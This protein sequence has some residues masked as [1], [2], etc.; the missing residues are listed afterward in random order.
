MPSS[1]I[2]LIVD[3]NP[4]GR[5]NLELLLSRQGYTLTFANSG[6]EALA[7]AVKQPPD[8]ILLDVMM[9]EM[10]GFEVCRRLR[11]D[12]LLREIPV[13]LLT[14]LGDRDS[15]LVGIEAG[16]D[17]F[18]SKP[19]DRTELRTRIKTILRLNRYRRLHAERL[20]FEWAVEHAN[21]GYIV[22]DAKGQIQYANPRAVLYLWGS[23]DKSKAPNPLLDQDFLTLAAQRY[24]FEPEASWQQWQ[25]QQSIPD[26]RLYLVRPETAQ[27]K[28][29]WLQVDPLQTSMGEQMLRLQDV[30]E[31]ISN[32]RVMWS[33][34][35]QVN[36]KLRTPLALHMGNLMLLRE[37]GAESIAHLDGDV[38]DTME[39]I[40]RSAE[41]LQREVQSVLSVVDSLSLAQTETD[42]FLLAQ[43]P[44]LIKFLSTHV[45]PVEIQVDARGAGDAQ[46]S[47]SQIAMEL[48][49]RELFE[50]A[51]KFH[52]HKCPQLK[53]TVECHSQHAIIQVQDDGIGL[54]PEQLERMWTPYYQ[55]EKTFTGQ[56]P[57]MGLGLTMASSLIWEAGGECRSFNRTDQHGLVVELRLPLRLD[58]AQ[59]V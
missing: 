36:H 50:N 56:V 25:T 49:L 52:P 3:D 8:L 42:G 58:D 5:E 18:I 55:V 53:V 14:A 48:V 20:R 39:E 23:H 34:Q 31:Q 46:L 6:A 17:D 30:T 10:D 33:F 7:Q 32:L 2:V 1:N 38:V 51:V 41:R 37:I 15:M 22:L 19:F 13:I 40:Y 16:A 28:T 47:I 59:I 44:D 57:G 45:L 21:E 11:A 24:Q 9:P 29:L 43:L 27:T 54:P 4:L 35:Y 12:P 26:G